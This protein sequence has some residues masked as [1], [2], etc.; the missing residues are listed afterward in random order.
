M[1]HTGAIANLTTILRCIS[2]AAVAGCVCALPG[3]NAKLPWSTL[4]YIPWIAGAAFGCWLVARILEWKAPRAPEAVVWGLAALIGTYGWVVT[5]FPSAMVERV[6]GA[7]LELDKNP[8]VAFGTIDQGLSEQAMISISVALM[9]VV[10]ALDFGAE[11]RTR[12]VLALAVTAAG[13]VTAIAGLWLQTPADLKELWQVKNVPDSVFGL[14]WYHGNTA[15]FLN[16]AWPAGVWL[17]VLLLSQ[18][19]RTFPQQMALSLLV[20]A[21]MMEIV[22][23]FVNVSKMGH[24]LLIVEM[25][26][27]AGAGLVVWRPRLAALPFSYKRLALF[28]FIGVGLLVLGAWLSGAATGMGRWNIFAA[29]HFDDPARRHAALMALQI[30][31]E[32]GWTGTGPGTFEWVSP[33]Y[34]ALDPV[35]QEGRWRHAHNDYAEFFA[36]WGWPGTVFFLLL[37]AL[38]GRRLLNAVKQALV[39]DR[40]AG[41][42]FQRR[43]GL[44]CFSVAILSALIH[45]VVDFPLQ[46]DASRHLFAVMLGAVLGMTHSSGSSA[47][48]REKRGGR[49]EGWR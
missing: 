43:T 16:L 11:R 25:L 21:V 46:I 15:A 39:D 23:V 10:M 13:F 4:P 19:Q 8:W 44:V 37:L 45:A 30:G 3:A 47:G 6:S 5:C 12:Y 7:I 24:L 28:V 17:C 41:M 1:G 27:L 26:V 48:R 38:P 36:E 49:E 35:L 34:A 20:V 9:L 29:R 14:F 40:R 42:S 31:W 2:L 22:A 18:A 32:H 33:H